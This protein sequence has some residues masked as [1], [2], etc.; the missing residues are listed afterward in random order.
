VGRRV[1]KEFKAPEVLAL[2]EA[3]REGQPTV[4]PYCEKS[5]VVRTPAR[6]PGEVSVGRVVLRCTSCSRRVS[7]IEKAVA[8]ASE[9]S[10]I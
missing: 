8:E 6:A 9:H 7:F 1:Y 3:D 2:I 10:W 4:C 5:S